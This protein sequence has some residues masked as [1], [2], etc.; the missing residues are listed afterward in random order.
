MPETW[1]VGP[2][3]AEQSALLLAPEPLDAFSRLIARYVKVARISPYQTSASVRREVEPLA[4][5]DLHLA[6]ETLVGQMIEATG[7]RA[8]LIAILCNEVLKDLTLATR[9]LTESHLA[10]AMDSQSLRSALDA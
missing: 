5:L 3:D 1:W 9:A 7:Q 2:D 10:R 6:P 8:N 4:A